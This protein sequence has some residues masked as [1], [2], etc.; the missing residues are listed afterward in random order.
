MAWWVLLLAGVLGVSAVVVSGAMRAK[1]GEAFNGWVGWSGVAVL[2]L[3]AVLVA[4]ELWDRITRSR[5]RRSSG[6]TGDAENELAA[7]VLDQARTARSRLLGAGEAGDEAANVRFA[8]GR[9]QFREVGGA[10]RGDLD[11]VVDYYQSLRPRRLVILGEPGAGKTVLA[12]EL[13]I[14]LLEQRQQN[15]SIPVPVLV[16]AA[17]YDT[18]QPWEDWMAAHLA[19]R[20]RMPI[21]TAT[22]LVRDRRILPVIDG[23]DE[24]DV[25]GEP[26]QAHEPV[27]ARAQVAALNAFMQDTERAA[28]VVT[29]RQKEYQGLSVGVDKATHIEMLRLNG[30]ESAAFLSRQLR[31]DAEKRT[32]KPVLAD[33]RARPRGLLAA[34]LATPWRM[35]L[36]LTDFRDG[37]DAAVLLPG[38]AP[39][40]KPELPDDYAKRI[41]GLLLARYVPSAVRLHDSDR[42]YTPQQVQGWLTALAKGLDWQARHGGS[43]TD[44][45]LDTWWRPAARWAAPVLHVALVAVLALPWLAAAL[46]GG[47]SG[48]A[49]IGALSLIFAGWSGIPPRHKRLKAGRLTTSSGLLKFVLSFGGFLGGV[50]GLGFVVHLFF[51]TWNNWLAPMLITGL[52]TG[53]VFGFWTGVADASPQ[54]VGPRETIQADGQYGLVLGLLTCLMFWLAEVLAIPLEGGLAYGLAVQF[55]AGSTVGLGFGLSMGAPAWTRYH[56]AVMIAAIRRSMPLR[57]GASL[58]WAY[59]AGL[60]RLSGTAYQFRHRQLQDWAL[61]DG[62]NTEENLC[63]PDEHGAV[64]SNQ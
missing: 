7:V 1:P 51:R 48:L 26:E 59:Q 28:V 56:I 61:F 32:W 60:L 35:T 43:P 14:G 64:V 36:A 6:P 39:N 15:T 27:R 24:M 57:F 55:A 20:F 23:L 16:S 11:T 54:A 5:E 17:A 62:D 47:N 10:R 52:L 31:G 8:K 19:Q 49:A 33:L 9:G 12:M 41:N 38:L 29:C 44:I 3:T 46:D 45:A 58:D 4:L 53:L 50:L 63:P 30:R 37:R 13:L 22:T 34:E 2:V 21:E 42:R 18:N 40:G 25:A